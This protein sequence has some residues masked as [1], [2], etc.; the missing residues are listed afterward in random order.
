MYVPTSKGPDGAVGP[1]SGIRQSGEFRRSLSQ[2]TGNQMTQNPD[3]TL[4]PYELN[5]DPPT[6]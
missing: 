1:R 6:Q 3:K 4:N 2:L 5:L